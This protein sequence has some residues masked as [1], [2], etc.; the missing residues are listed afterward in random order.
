MKQ[1]PN[2][3]CVE[4]GESAVLLNEEKPLCAN[5]YLEEFGD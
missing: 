2:E 3:V 1:E 4:C 5:C